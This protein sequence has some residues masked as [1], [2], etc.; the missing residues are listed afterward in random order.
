M[1]TTQETHWNVGGWTVG[2]ETDDV[3]FIEELLDHLDQNLS[4]D[5]SRV[6]ST[7]MSNGGFMSYELAC[8]LSDRIAAI[9]SVTGTMTP[10]TYANCKPTRPVSVLQ[11]HGLRD[12]VVPYRGNGIMTPIDQVMSYWAS[13]NNCAPGPEITQIA[14]LTEDGFGGNR[15]QFYGC[16]NNS[17]VE[18]ITLDAMGHDWPISNSIYRSQDLDAASEIWEFLSSFSL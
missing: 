6:Y 8:Q 1:Q 16:D 10:Q 2:S 9:A 7:G 15:R 11:I 4:I 17:S 3:L 14:D 5:R 12:S 18:L 13:E